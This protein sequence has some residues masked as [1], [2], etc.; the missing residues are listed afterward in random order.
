MQNTRKTLTR[1]VV[2]REKYWE[3]VDTNV[4]GRNPTELVQQ[5]KGQE[6]RPKRKKAEASLHEDNNAAQLC[7]SMGRG[8]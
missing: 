7:H 3:S 5:L 2:K 6:R 1:F 8:Y 4:S